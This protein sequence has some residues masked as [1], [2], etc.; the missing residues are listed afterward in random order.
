MSTTID[1]LHPD[2][3]VY[4]NTMTTVFLY[5]LTVEDAREFCNKIDRQ[6]AT[7]DKY[8]IYLRCNITDDVPLPAPRR[9]RF[10]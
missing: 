10:A 6:E 5:F 7:I 1:A 2:Y 3:G 9:N 4:P 8:T